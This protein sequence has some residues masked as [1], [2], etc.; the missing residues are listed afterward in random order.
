[1]FLKL[2]VKPGAKT[3][4]ITLEADGTWKVKIKAPPVDG[5]ANAYLIRYLSEVLHLAQSKISIKTGSGS[6]HK[7][8]AIDED[9]EQLKAKIDE[10]FNKM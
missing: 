2:K 4:A 6:S 7:L 3:D 10:L 5:R 1:M 8:V 9:A